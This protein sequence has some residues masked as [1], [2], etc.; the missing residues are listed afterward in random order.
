[1]AIEVFVLNPAYAQ[2]NE[3]EISKLPTPNETIVQANT[4][5]S[6]NAL[7]L[8]YSDLDGLQFRSSMGA[9]N[10]QTY[11]SR[12]GRYEVLCNPVKQI[13]FV[14]SSGFME[15][16]VGTINPEPKA[17]FYFKVEK[18]IETLS[19]STPTPLSIFTEPSNCELWLNGIKT[20]ES[21]PFESEVNSGLATI[22]IQKQN[23][24]PLDTSVYLNSGEKAVFRFALNKHKGF[25]EIETNPVGSSIYIDDEYMGISPFSDSIEVG[26]Y[27]LKINTRQ[28]IPLVQTIEIQK[29]KSYEFNLS[30][31]ETKSK[32]CIDADGNKYK[33]VTIGN[34]QWMAENLKTQRFSNGDP[35]LEIKNDYEWD[36]KEPVRCQYENNKR[37]AKKYGEL[38]NWYVVNDERNVCPSGWKIPSDREWT[39]L[40][41]HID[42]RAGRP[43]ESI[44]YLGHGSGLQSATAGGK[45][46]RISG[47]WDKPNIDAT[48]DSKFSAVPGGCRHFRGYFESEGTGAYWWTATPVDEVEAWNRS[49]HSESGEL[50]RKAFDKEYGL[51]I[52]CI[53]E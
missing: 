36:S 25:I 6:D 27:Q 22:R 29:G 17:V 15:V 48:N 11:N 7:L 37:M 32:D 31:R 35:I 45:M 20:A 4:Q 28:H 51:S 21:T 19:G 12:A 8:I 46:K 49:V 33:T 44:N 3:F 30:L 1:M 47:G 38:Y 13:I 39:E 40:A 23:H 2:L 52:R 5:F 18:K 42:H 53:K 34:Q 14:A 41:V 26:S 43:D 24:H 50:F 9:I 10:K 16:R